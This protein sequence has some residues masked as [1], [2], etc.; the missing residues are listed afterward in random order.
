MAIDMINKIKVLKILSAISFCTL[1]AALL[2]SKFRGECFSHSFIKQLQFESEAQI[3]RFP[4]CQS[5]RARPYVSNYQSQQDIIKIKNSLDQVNELYRV[6]GVSKSSESKIEIS[7]LN[8][9]SDYF[10]VSNNK[11]I[12][13]RGVIDQPE[14]LQVAIL[15]KL[16]LDAELLDSNLNS[17]DKSL[18]A[19]IISSSIW[20]AFG[21]KAQ[22]HN[23]MPLHHS[24]SSMCE[25]KLKSLNLAN[26]CAQGRLLSGPNVQ[27]LALQGYLLDKWS[28]A[29]SQ[30]RPYYRFQLLKNILSKTT[31]FD[32]V[33]HLNLPLIIEPILTQQEIGWVKLV[34]KLILGRVDSESAKEIKSSLSYDLFPVFIYL[35]LNADYDEINNTSIVQPNWLVSSDKDLN[36]NQVTS[37]M[38]RVRES[39]INQANQ[40]V[41]IK[42]EPPSVR[43][44]MM[45]PS[46][47]EKVYII[48]ECQE[49]GLNSVIDLQK[50]GIEPFLASRPEISYFLAH[51]PSL[52]WLGE[53][54]TLNPFIL[55]ELEQFEHPIF[56][57]LGWQ[58]KW[59]DQ[60]SKS[61]KVTASVEAIQKYRLKAKESLDF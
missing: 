4:S 16:V 27:K 41:L 42:C 34:N 15:Y 56:K 12:F 17:F 61:I 39:L 19:E 10:E 7:F 44:L 2:L 53:K 21:L 13:D 35:K 6:I 49:F 33:E 28:K 31:A 22:A 38:G 58:D 25:S 18:L 54:L 59:F 36:L 48:K 24:L 8:K 47:I 20:S 50:K 40:A 60:S 5:S 45:L 46:S 23:F 1:T 37:F 57:I 55:I 51:L 29:F 9:Q 26:Q 30:V 11:L 43:E 14:R 52:R 3:Y 32:H